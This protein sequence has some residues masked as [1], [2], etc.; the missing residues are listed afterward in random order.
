MVAG[1]H[2]ARL[3]CSDMPSNTA[4]TDKADAVKVPED[5][6]QLVNLLEVSEKEL[7]ETKMQLKAKVCCTNMKLCHSFCE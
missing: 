1:L 6:A 5:V 4:E 7:F 2:Q 3:Q